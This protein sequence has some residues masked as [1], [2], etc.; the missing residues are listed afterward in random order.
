MKHLAFWIIVGAVV[1]N[2]ALPPGALANTVG[3]IGVGLGAA[4]PGLAGAKRI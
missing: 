2:L 3:A 1:V 4:L